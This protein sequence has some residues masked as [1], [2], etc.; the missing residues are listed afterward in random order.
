M[1]L[2]RHYIVS[3]YIS[4]MLSDDII[5]SMEKEFYGS[6]LLP[7]LSSQTH[8]FIVTLEKTFKACGHVILQACAA[9]L[10]RLAIFLDVKLLGFVVGFLNFG[11]ICQPH[12]SNS[13]L[14]LEHETQIVPQHNIQEDRRPQMRIV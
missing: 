6:S 1:Y 11:T 7:A 8:L 13:S 3:D 9:V 5:R 2:T 14:T 12:L 4:V 10:F